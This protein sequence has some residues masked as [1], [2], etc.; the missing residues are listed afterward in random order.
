MLGHIRDDL[1]ENIW[2]NFA[3]GQHLNHLAK[4][5]PMETQMDVNLW[6][7]LLNISKSQIYAAATTLKVPHLKN[8]TPSWCNR[9]KF[10]EHFYAQTHAQYGPE[11]DDKLL[12]VAA[13][14]KAQ[15]AL[16]DRLLYQ[17]IYESWNAETKTINVEVAIEAKLD[18][19]AW[20]QIFEHT[21][22]K[23]LKVNRPSIHAVGEFLR[24]I[25]ANS[26]RPLA[27]AMGKGLSI[28]LSGNILQ[29]NP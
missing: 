4:M 1:V 16:I 12:E 26:Q 13:A 7:P 3:R 28:S 6:R 23:Y 9:G 19:N 17:K 22:H 8:T 10:R 5:E 29:F 25:S 24:R 2:T 14:L 11:V 15:A 27:M 20:L 21:C 18:A